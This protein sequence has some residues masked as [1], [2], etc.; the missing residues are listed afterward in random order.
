MT[1]QILL[2]V[3]SIGTPIFIGLILAYF[4][5][6]NDKRYAQMEKRAEL[7]KKESI[8]SLELA[9]ANAKL[10]YACAMALKRGETNGEVE[11]GVKAYKKA[12]KAR[13]DFLKETHA[14]VMS[15]R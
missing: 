12:M 13:E 9:E 2:L 15:E 1:E 14:D 7:R 8:I 5:R 4:Q 10:S 11:E 6:R 3:E